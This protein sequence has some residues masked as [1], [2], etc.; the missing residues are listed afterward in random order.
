MASTADN[1]IAV[2]EFA[3]GQV[4]LGRCI[5]GLIAVFSYIKLKIFFRTDKAVTYLKC[6]S[7]GSSKPFSR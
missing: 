6:A 4:S 5:V 7:N 2:Y 1:G 3:N